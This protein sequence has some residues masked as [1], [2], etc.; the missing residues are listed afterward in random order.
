MSRKRPLTSPHPSERTGKK[1]SRNQLGEA[2]RGAQNGPAAANPHCT[3]D[4]VKRKRGGV[5]RGNIF[6]FKGMCANEKKGAVV[7]QGA[8]V[9]RGKSSLIRRNASLRRKGRESP[10]EWRKTEWNQDGLKMEKVR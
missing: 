3:R 4:D 10:F 5:G 8:D 1:F 7:G 6:E 2:R 9:N